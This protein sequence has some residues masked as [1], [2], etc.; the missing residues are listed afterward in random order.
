MLRETVMPPERGPGS[1]ST[2]KQVI[3]SGATAAKATMLARSPLVTHI[4][5]P[6]IT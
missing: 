5:V 2:M 4:L 1:F 3:P 6:S